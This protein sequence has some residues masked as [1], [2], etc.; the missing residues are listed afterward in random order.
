MTVTEQ[1]PA[2][3]TAAPSGVRIVL[4]PTGELAPVQR[5]LTARP[6][7]LSGRTI[8]L[9]DITSSRCRRSAA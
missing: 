5:E 3:A 8:G 6:G 7:D 2:P 9:L 4:D 1:A